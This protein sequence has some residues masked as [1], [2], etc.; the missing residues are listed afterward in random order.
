MSKTGLYRSTWKITEVG[1]EGAY[2]VNS[3]VYIHDVCDVLVDAP[4][5]T[6]IGLDH[7]RA[8]VVVGSLTITSTCDGAIGIDFDEHATNVLS[9]TGYD[10]AGHKRSIGLQVTRV[11]SGAQASHAGGLHTTDRVTR[12]TSARFTISLTDSG[13]GEPTAPG[14]YTY[15][16]TVGYWSD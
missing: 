7:A 6:T 10:S 8:G 5:S 9:A 16:G 13:A 2:T 3:D 11:G 4:P 14:R 15:G 12:T 1:G